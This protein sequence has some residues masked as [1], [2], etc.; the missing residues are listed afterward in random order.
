MSHY[1]VCVLLPRRPE[2]REDAEAMVGALMAP[3][4][5]SISVEPY[6][7]PCRC[8]GRKATIA[9]SEKVDAAFGDMRSVRAKFWER[10]DVKEAERLHGFD[11][12]ELAATW[13]ATIAPR[14]A[15]EAELFAAHPERMS[16]DPMCGKYGEAWWTDPGLISHRPAHVKL[17]DPYTDGGGC[18]G[19]GVVTTTYNPRSQWDWWTIGGRWTGALTKYDPEQ[20][21]R[22]RETCRSCG[23]SGK[24]PSAL[25]GSSPCAQCKGTGTDVKWPTE[26]VDHEGDVIECSKVD[27]DFVPFAYLLP[28]GEWHERA[29]MGWFGM[30]SNDKRP[31]LWAEEWRAARDAHAASGGWVAAVDGH[32]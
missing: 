12:D 22:N 4:D 16:P 29:E 14:K 3:F 15:M 32:V 5:E 20:D 9:V 10:P 7:R 6:E 13:A 24:S 11:S 25:R 21:P 17:G 8:I 31:D 30:T 23:G 2:S 18:Q 26:W 19:T 1:C 28:N 27:R